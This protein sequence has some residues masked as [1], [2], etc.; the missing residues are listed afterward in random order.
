LVIDDGDIDITKSTEGIETKQIMTINGGDINVVSSDDGFNAGG[1]NDMFGGMGGGQGDG[2]GGQDMQPQMNDGQQPSD[3]PEMPSG[4]MQNGGMPEMNGE[5][6]SGDMPEMPNGDMQNGDKP[7]DDGRNKGGFGG[8]MGSPGMGNNSSEI[9]S[10]H[11]IQINGG[12][13]YI[14]AQGDG[15]DSNG[16]LVIA[17]GSV[18]VDGPTNGGDSALDS[19]GAMMIHGG[20][21]IAA[22]ALGMVEAPNSN[23]QQNVV[24]Y[25]LSETASAGTKFEVKT[26]SGKTILSY[27]PVKNYQSVIF[28]S[29]KLE[30]GSEYTIYVG[31]EEKDSFTISDTVTEVGTSSNGGFGGGKGGMNGDDKPSD[32]GMNGGDKP[33]DNGMNGGNMPNGDGNFG[34][35]DRPNDNGGMNGNMNG[36]MGGGKGGAGGRGGRNQMQAQ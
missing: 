17:G 3:M 26:S 24:N 23:S 15:I 34:G 5:A 20:E 31:G 21:V 14:N 2:K 36:G 27:T 19:D 33:S 35:G 18:T 28:S 9:S 13:I 32:N 30:T 16:S 12:T 1:G 4:D 7:S 6:P 25:S 11:H 8:G 10:E 29:D 22:G